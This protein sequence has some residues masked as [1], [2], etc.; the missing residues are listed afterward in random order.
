MFLIKLSTENLKKIIDKL[1]KLNVKNEIK[2]K[3]LED[4]LYNKED[5]KY[6][7][8]DLLTLCFLKMFG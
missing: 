2:I 4:E 8:N 6:N 5:G 3:N 1:E 7:I